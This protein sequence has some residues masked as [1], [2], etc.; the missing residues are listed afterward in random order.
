M[1]ENTTPTQPCKINGKNCLI[2][3]SPI[4]YNVDFGGLPCGEDTIQFTRHSGVCHILPNNFLI[5]GSCIYRFVF[6]EIEDLLA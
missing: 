4:T 3:E 5:S 2:G 1:N 6:D